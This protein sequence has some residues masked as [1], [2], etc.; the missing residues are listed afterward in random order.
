MSTIDFTPDTQDNN[1]TNPA[2]GINFTPSSEPTPSAQSIQPAQQS[3]SDKIW[4]GLATAGNIA[5]A[6]FPGKQLGQDIGTLAG[7]GVTAGKEALG[8]VPKG[9]TS[10]YDLSAPSPLQATGD[11]AKGAALVGTLGAGVPV[12]FA[13]AALQ[14][15]TVGGLAGAGQAASNT[16][17]SAIPTGKDLAKVGTGAAIGAGTGAA[18]GAG[19][20]GLSR[21]VASLGNKITNS[22]IRPSKADIEDGFSVNTIQKYNLGGSLSTMYDKTESTIAD[23]SNQLNSKLEASDASVDLA[24]VYEDTANSLSSNKIRG[25]GSNT[26]INGA[27]EQLQNEVN[28]LGRSEVSIPEAQLVKQA[29]GKMGA[30]QFGTIDP[31][32]TAREQVYNAFYRNLKTAI[33]DNSPAGVQGI[34]KQLSELIPVQNAII[35]RIP[36]ADRNSALSLS[37]MVGLVGSVMNPKALA[38]LGISLAQKS[39][40]VANLLSRYVAPGAAALSTPLAAGSATLG[41]EVATGDGGI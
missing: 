14:G 9:T 17:G 8:M 36:V 40:S 38:G 28:A 31:E 19:T 1:G 26:A 21:L 32:A 41:S 33:E 34:N 4:N 7:Y 12:D 3:L 5:G 22:V 6:V 18:V 37:D 29:S 27:L 39:G 30:W 35:R 13:S 25:F 11:V 2:D 16:S 23:L 20:F 24:K 15:A 10:R